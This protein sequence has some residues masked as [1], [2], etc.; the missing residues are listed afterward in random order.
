MSQKQINDI[1]FGSKSENDVYELLKKN[2]KDLQKSSNKYS[3]YDFYND[4]TY[5]ELKTRRNKKD[6]YKTSMLGNNKIKFFLKNNDK[7]TFLFFNYTD[8]LF[9]MPL[10]NENIK[11]CYVKK[12]GRWDRGKDE[13]C[14]I[15]FIPNH[16]LSPYHTLDTLD[17]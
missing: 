12:G 14:D 8:G 11:E 1:K 13:T 4:D 9:Y 15:F 7:N 17:N 5:I 6:Q 2:F 3:I 10:T 16:L